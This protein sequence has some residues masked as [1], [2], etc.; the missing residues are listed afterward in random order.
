MARD[1]H[2]LHDSDGVVSKKSK[3]S[4]HNILLGL[5]RCLDLAVILFRWQ[6][7]VDRYT[8][9]S[10][11]GSP[12]FV[13]CPCSLAGGLYSQKIFAR[14]G[15]RIFNSIYYGGDSKSGFCNAF[16]NRRSWFQSCFIILSIKLLLILSIKLLLSPML[17]LLVVLSVSKHRV[18]DPE[19]CIPKNSINCNW[20]DP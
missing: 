6:A 1:V 12:W 3:M 15:C 17:A 5:N 14:R 7:Q 4:M 11:P 9:A 2:H 8:L 20:L 18:I 19:M 10:L 16:C 13:L